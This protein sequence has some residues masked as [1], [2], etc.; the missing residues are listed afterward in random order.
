M[1]DRL[2]WGILNHRKLVVSVFVAAALACACMTPLVKTNYDMTE[3]LPPE[4][5]S[6]RAVA[7]MT[8]DFSQSMPNANVLVNDV[9]IAEAQVIKDEIASVDGVESV[10]WLD[11]VLDL[12]QPLETLDADA[13]EQY[14]RD[15]SAKYQVTITEGAEGSTVPAIRELVDTYG[16]G[17]GVAGEAADNQAM[18]EGTS[19]QVGLAMALVVPIITV[20]LVLST[21]SWIEPLLFYAA[22]GI[23]I[24]INMGTNAFLD[25]VSF[26]T[27]SVSPIL[28]LA[29]SLDYAIFLLH[30]FA[31]HRKTEPTTEAAMAL[32]MRESISTIAASAVTTLFGFAALSFMQFQIGVDLGLNLVK[33]VALSFVSVTVFL[34]ALTVMCAGALDKTTHRKLMPD[35]SRIGKPL[36][37]IRIPA[38]LL[39]FAVA[40]PA[41]LGQ[42]NVTF[43]YL[44]SAPDPDLRYGA[45]Y[46]A[47]EETFGQQNAAALLV[48]RGD[49]AA[50]AA[51][52]EE[53]EQLG[54]VK[55]VMSYASTVGTT[56]PTEFLDPSIVEQFYSDDWARIVAYIDAEAESEEAFATVQ[57]IQDLAGA[58]YDEYYMAGQSANLYD[59]A[60][61]IE[62][63]N[64]RVS[65]I[66]IVTIFLVVAITFRSLL[67]P[68]CLVL[69]IETG[70]WINLCIPYYTG[71]TLNFIGYLVI[72][73]VQLGATIDYGIL[74][75]THYLRWRKNVPAREAIYKALGE[76]VPSLIVSAG[77][78]ASAGF[79]LGTTSDV[80][81]VELLGFL[82]ARGALISLAMVTCFLPAL[83]VYFDGPIRVTT[84][85]ADFFRAKADEAASMPSSNILPDSTPDSKIGDI[86]V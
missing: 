61:I 85:K 50:E 71:D 6:T 11:D 30:A 22:I 15:G 58:Y 73:T 69:A 9:T 27:F 33:G 53:I 25:G 38:M 19:T 28:Q 74:L 35:F 3:Y 45:D 1:L 26:I 14:Y 5:Q 78:L 42:A 79:A 60:Q 54:T 18:M 59:M 72:N 86:H 80:A 43:T 84:W 47:M 21:M 10:M 75:T 34:P 46:Y 29:V 63:D 76:T 44:T 67:L 81:V 41:F 65:L 40:V 48:P 39:C 66:A 12:T 13:V 37:T 70:I 77:I 4:A 49:V 83:L 55:S 23:S 68:V 52:A 56:I 7:I 51:L 8:E 36:S 62:V 82:L 64:L 32:A 17:N 2:I 31:R 24:L 20:L 16:E 57:S